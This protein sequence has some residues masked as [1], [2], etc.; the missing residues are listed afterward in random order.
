MSTANSWK[1]KKAYVDL[2]MHNPK[3]LTPEGLESAER[4]MRSAMRIDP[5]AAHEFV[6]PLERIQRAR[7]GHQLSTK[8]N[9]SRAQRYEH[10]ARIANHNPKYVHTPKWVIKE[11]QGIY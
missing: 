5:H 4:H 3:D 2:A 8:K 6:K 9:I 10:L 7:L 1:L 11:R